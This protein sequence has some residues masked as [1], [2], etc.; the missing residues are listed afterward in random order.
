M[1]RKVDIIFSKFL[2]LDHEKQERIINAA[3][4]E[5]AQKGYKN[6]S[7]NEIV[8]EAN[9]GKGM[10]FHY[11]NSKKDLYLFLYDYALKVLG[12]EFYE[13]VDLNERDILLRWHQIALLKIEIIGKHPEMF[14]FVIAVN[15]ETDKEVKEELIK[16]NKDF[17]AKSYGKIYENIDSSMFR[18]GIDIKKAID[19]ASWTIEGLSAR[20]QE[21]VKQS[22]LDELNYDEIMTEVDNYLEFLRKSFYK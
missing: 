7:T 8:K 15:T 9:I 17:I 14:N 1:Q 10:L 22:S 20:G 2:N 6:A 18:E 5:F 4:K 3:M 21:R 13:K 12:R 11:F 19:V 16:T